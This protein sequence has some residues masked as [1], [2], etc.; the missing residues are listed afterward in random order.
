LKILDLGKGLALG[1]ELVARA[2]V[3]TSGRGI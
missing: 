1:H 2:T 3:V